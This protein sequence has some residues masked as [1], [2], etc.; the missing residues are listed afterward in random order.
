MVSEVRS[1]AKSIMA[2]LK[3]SGRGHQTAAADVLR[4]WCWQ[5]LW[6][7]TTRLAWSMPTQE[8]VVVACLHQTDYYLVLMIE[9]SPVEP[10]P[11]LAGK[12]CRSACP[13]SQIDCYLRCCR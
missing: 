3:S 1:T 2:C 7:G 10:I 6:S 9:Q 13:C 11:Q 12:D 5:E 4:W 8:L